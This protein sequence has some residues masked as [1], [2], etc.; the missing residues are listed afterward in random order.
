MAISE[1]RLRR[2]LAREPFFGDE[3]E[4]VDVFPE[5]SSTMDV[6]RERAE[7][8]APEGTVVVSERQL[9]GRGRRGRTWSSPVGGAWL[10]LLLRP[11]EERRPVSSLSVLSAVGTARAL[12]EAYG[13]PITVK[14]P[15]DLLINRRKLGGILIDLA[16]SGESL[17]RAIV[18]VG[19]NV[20]NEPPERIPSIS[21]SEALGRPVE[22][23]ACVASILRGIAHWYGTFLTE[24]FDVVRGEW[25]RLSAVDVGEEIW[26]VRQD[27]RYEARV[28]GLSKLGE[29]LVERDGRTESLV[30]EEVTLRFSGP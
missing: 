15:N 29:L 14:W 17:T 11:E 19:I 30:A 9:R 26:V 23:E 28:R 10:S 27:E 5:L 4:R 6:M 25:E 1:R 24:G 12:H 20:N 8:G 3:G 22:L 13:V 21:L 16:S 7:S 2:E 18:G